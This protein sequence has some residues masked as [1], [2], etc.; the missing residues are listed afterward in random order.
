MNTIYLDNAATSFPKPPE[1]ERAMVER[2]RACGNPGRG[3]HRLAV[4]AEQTLDRAR[5][6]LYR[7]L[8]GLDPRRFVLT[9]NGTD[10]LHLAIHGTVHGAADRTSSRAIGEASGSSI[11]HVVTTVLE[12]NSVVRAVN[13]LAADGRI[14]LTRVGCDDS[15]VLDPDDIAR[16]VRRDTALVV[17]TMASN[18]LGTLQ[19]AAAI[20]DAIRDRSSALILADAAQIVGAVPLSLAKLGADLVAF[21]GHKGL[22]GPMGTG[23]LWIGP[24]AQPRLD[25]QVGARIAP[26]RAG[27]TGDS[28]DPLMPAQL[29]RRFEGGTPNVVGAA[30]LAAGTEWLLH[31]G[32]ERI[33]AHER[34]LAEELASRLDALA[35]VRVVGSRN[36]SVRIGVVSIA[37]EDVDPAE[38]AATLD[39]AFGIAVRPGLHCA[40][41]AHE[42]AGTFPLGTIRASV[43]P[44][45][46]PSHIESLVEAMGEIIDATRP[47]TPRHDPPAPPPSTPS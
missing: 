44:F 15:G 5:L 27:G 3:G 11:P 45:N 18:A 38:L 14:E 35:G 19:P 9:L 6:A 32:V 2:L 25:S 26:V 1:V 13:H 39:A 10:A 41:G 16:A 17:F 43:G 46:E 20:I 47:S 24:E 34:R 12:H 4:E 40:P 36:P 37:I 22:L 7:L 31:H 8:D 29:P 28:R 21:P 30:G 23:I 42:A 33:A